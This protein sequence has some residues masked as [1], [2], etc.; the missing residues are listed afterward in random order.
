MDFGI[1]C[2]ASVN[3][4]KDVAFA[5][6]NGFTHAWIAD[7]QMVWAD[8]YQCLALCAVNTRTIKLGTNVT[9]P[10]SRISPVTACSFA[11]LNALAPGR[12]IMGI[13]IGNTSR[14]TLGMP[15]AGFRSYV[16]MWKCAVHFGG[17]R[18]CPT[19]PCKNIRVTRGKVRSQ[20]DKDGLGR[21]ATL[22]H[23]SAGIGSPKCSCT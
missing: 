6:T 8:P 1:L 20:S 9:N 23:S 7:S 14:R 3:S 18:R 15:A 17:A 19:R 12:V 4:W 13:G 2:L 21:S 10:S 5:E 16:P 22:A 11:T